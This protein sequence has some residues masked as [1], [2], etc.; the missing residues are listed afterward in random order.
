MHAKIGAEGSEGSTVTIQR[1][2][3]WERLVRLIAVAIV[4]LSW[5]GSTTVAAHELR[6]ADP[7]STIVVAAEYCPDS[8]EWAFLFL[9]N[10]YRSQYGLPALT[11]SR[12]LGAAAEQHSRDMANEN[13]FNHTLSD[14]T[15]WSDNIRNHGYDADTALGENIAAGRSA[16]SDVF[17]LWVNS[18]THRENMLSP[19]FVAIGIGRASNSDS[20][21]GWYWTTTFG[22]KTDDQP[23]C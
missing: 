22:G 19:S 8:Q 16:A 5:S 21:F 15:S 17:D 7:N 11:L 3:R 9:I 6:L 14:G 10:D 20:T 23:N 1:G 18:T 2:W 4:V 12:T 13:Y